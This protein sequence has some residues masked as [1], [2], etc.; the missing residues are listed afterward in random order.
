M[1]EVY[2]KDGK[3]GQAVR[4]LL[5]IKT[6]KEQTGKFSSYI[7]FYTDYSPGRKSP[8]DTDIFMH[9]TLAE[10]KIKFAALK[11]ENIKKGWEK[12]I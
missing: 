9:Q 12:V 3:N 2:T 10:A 6:N 8:L 4:K 7:N 11:E 5:L 1:K